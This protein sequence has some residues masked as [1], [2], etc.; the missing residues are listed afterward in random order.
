MLILENLKGK[1]K[2]TKPSSI[3]LMPERK[4]QLCILLW[5][6]FQSDFIL[7]FKYALEFKIQIGVYFVITL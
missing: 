4:R 6:L 3:S 2:T 5:V 1:K 7:K